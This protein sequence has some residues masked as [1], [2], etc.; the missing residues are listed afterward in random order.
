MKPGGQQ[1]ISYQKSS[2][3]GIHACDTLLS[4]KKR[5]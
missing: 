5:L 2:G 3:A 4:E 1:T